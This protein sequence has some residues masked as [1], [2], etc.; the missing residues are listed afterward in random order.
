VTVRNSDK[1]VLHNINTREMIGVE[2]GRVVKRTMFN[3]GQPDPGDI[4]QSIKPRRS[5]YIGINCE[6]H[7]FMFGFMM[8]P[9]HPYAV[10]VNDDG[11]YSIGDVPPGKYKLKAWHPRL[12]IKKTKIKVDAGG[13]VEANFS[14][15]AK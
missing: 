4:E 15:S 11:S 2:K 6:A 13:K 8:A 7:N 9:K 12:G 5:S 1:G 10:V 3:F 14:F